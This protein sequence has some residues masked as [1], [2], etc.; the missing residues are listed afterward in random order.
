VTTVDVRP[1]AQHL[2][3]QNITDLFVADIS[4][5]TLE[6]TPFHA[7]IDVVWIVV[8]VIGHYSTLVDRTI[9]TSSSSKLNF[10][11][12]PVISSF[13]SKNEGLI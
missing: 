3:S 8:I 13:P 9:Q 11:L 2:K 5:G 6:V 1:T 12:E 7:V 10:K 4:R